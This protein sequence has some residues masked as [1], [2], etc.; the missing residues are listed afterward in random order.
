MQVIKLSSHPIEKV[1]Y[2]GKVH[3]TG[4]REGSARSTDGRLD[5]QLTPP[6]AKGEGTNPLLESDQR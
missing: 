1:L 6:G 3:V 4:G 2:T 5:I